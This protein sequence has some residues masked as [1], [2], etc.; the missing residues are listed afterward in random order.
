MRGLP[1]FEWKITEIGWG[2]NEHG[3]LSSPPLWGDPRRDPGLGAR[4]YS[5]RDMTSKIRAEAFELEIHVAAH[6]KTLL[7]ISILAV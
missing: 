1:V 7:P 6:K 4:S 3:T 2:E 5:R